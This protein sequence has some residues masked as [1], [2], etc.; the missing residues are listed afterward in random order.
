MRRFL[1]LSLLIWSSGEYFVLPGSPAYARHSPFVV[2]YWAASE[3]TATTS[4]PASARNLRTMEEPPG[5]SVG[6][7]Y[8]SSGSKFRFQV[9][10]DEPE[11]GMG[12]WN[13]ETRALRKRKREEL[14]RFSDGRDRDDDVLLAARHV[15]HRDIRDVRRNLHFRHDV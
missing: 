1:T 3:A 15:G 11:R 5:V 8:G 9:W 6:E 4:K 2:S 13:P 14:C 12:A 10:F 7:L